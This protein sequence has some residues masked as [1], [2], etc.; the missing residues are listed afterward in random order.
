MFLFHLYWHRFNAYLLVS[1][2]TTVVYDKPL[3]S[4]KDAE[5]AIKN[6]IRLNDE[7]WVIIV[8]DAVDYYLSCRIHR[9]NAIDGGQNYVDFLPWLQ[10][11]PYIPYKAS[12]AAYYDLAEKTY[13]SLMDEAKRTLVCY[14][15]CTVPVV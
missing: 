4:G 3:K 6:I 2:L 10:Y 1:Q 5:D 13:R 12:A 15:W 7:L 8:R 9:I 11:I 14:M